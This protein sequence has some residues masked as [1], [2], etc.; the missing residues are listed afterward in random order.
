MRV[1]HPLTALY[2]KPAVSPGAPASSFQLPPSAQCSET[3]KSRGQGS[4]SNIHTTQNEVL[5]V[6]IV[7]FNTRGKTSI[8]TILIL[9]HF[10]SNISQ[11]ENVL[12]HKWCVRRRESSHSDDMRPS[13]WLLHGFTSL[14]SLCSNLSLSALVNGGRWVLSISGAQHLTELSRL[15]YLDLENSRQL[16]HSSPGPKGDLHSLFT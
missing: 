4:L 5:A 12:E 15:L 2:P 9:S 3:K 10:H 13:S 6:E 1:R 11:E 14:Y 8:I 7:C 16:K